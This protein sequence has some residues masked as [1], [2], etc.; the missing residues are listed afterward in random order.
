M[1]KQLRKVIALIMVLFTFSFAM[2]KQTRLSGLVRFSSPDDPDCAVVRVLDPDSALISY[3]MT[4]STG[5][6][7]INNINVNEGWVHVSSPGYEPAFQK[8]VFPDGEARL[9]F[10]LHPLSTQLDEVVV[11]GGRI[12]RHTDGHVVAFPDKE[13]KRHSFGG[14]DLL[15]N[16][17]VPGVTVDR[18]S[19]QV[20]AVFGEA[21]L[22]INGIK[23]TLQEVKAI[24][25]GDVISVEYYDSPTGVYAGDNAAVNYVVR[26]H[27]SGYFGE[28]TAD[29]KLGYWNGAYG[30]ASKLSRQSTSVQ[31][32]ADYG[33]TSA[34]SDMKTGSTDYNLNE[35]AVRED[36]AGLGGHSRKDN[37]NIHVDVTDSRGD[38]TLRGSAWLDVDD[39][40]HSTQHESINGSESQRKVVD[41]LWRGG[42]RFFSKYNISGRQTMELNAG[43][44]FTH[45]DYSY[46]FEDVRARI[47]N[48][49]LGRLW[50]ADVTATY[51]RQFSR[52]NSLAVKF[53]DFY[54]NSQVDYGNSNI[55]HSSLWSNEEILF[56]QYQHPLSAAVRLTL[57]PGLSAL[58]YRQGGRDGISI[59]SPRMEIRFSARLSRS[60]Y[61]MGT[62][63][64]GNSFPNIAS[65]T[66][67]ERSVNEYLVMRGNPDIE[68]TKLY[69][70]MWVYGWNTQ[71]FGLQVMARYQYSRNIPVSSY[72]TEANHI[73]ESWTTDENAGYLNS[74]I[75]MTYR[76]HPTVSLMLSGGYNRYDHTGYQKC[77]TAGF[78]G[79]LEAMYYWR[80]FVISASV[81]SPQKVMGMDLARVR[82]PWQYG[83][84]A[85]YSV[86]S[87]KFEAGVNNPFIKDGSYRFESF[88]PVYNYRYRLRSRSAGCYGFV[89]ASFTFNG[90]KKL[91]RTELSYDREQTEDAMIKIRP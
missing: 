82:T 58:Q 17:M 10:Q 80:D 45:N 13:E 54:K 68:N 50:N 25:T 86:A 36:I 56:V 66:T 33:F 44:S 81:S 30:I 62:A 43:A 48:E 37:G 72:S 55:S 90:G 79:R 19:G 39:S 18:N 12:I 31:V 49:S 78:D 89:K 53:V 84:S 47:S 34:P 52:G 15:A 38:R 71:A 29:Q 21:T 7:E 42:M 75:S 5:H 2:G 87:W 77:G 59:F 63:N 4:D 74:S 26:R 32:I 22:Y 11:K 24:P 70:T 6:Y 27:T 1:Y 51:S 85:G 73:V 40:P 88:N 16:M 3:A 14:I 64:I 65:F 83:L 60:M 23:A 69:Q 41:R 61:L 28:L 35:G 76:P 9:D 91:Q 57:Q 67:A 46:T 20:S 8:I